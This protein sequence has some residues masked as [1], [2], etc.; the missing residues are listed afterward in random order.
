MQ[1]DPPPSAT[2]APVQVVSF[3]FAFRNAGD[4]KREVKIKTDLQ[5]APV[6]VT[7]DGSA[8]P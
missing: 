8:A 1:L 4:F 6:V 3:K 7:I 5:D 2:P